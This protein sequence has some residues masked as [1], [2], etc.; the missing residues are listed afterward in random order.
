M[1]NSLYIWKPEIVIHWAE[2]GV[3]FY[4]LI[5]QNNLIRYFMF[6]F[7]IIVLQFVGHLL[8]GCTMG[9]MVT[10]SKRAFTTCCA[11]QVCCSQS[12]Y[13]PVR[14]LLIRG[15]AGGTQ[16]H[17]SRSSSVSCE[18]WC[19]QSFFW[20]LQVSLAFMGFDSKHEFIPPIILLGLLLCSWMCF[21]FVCLFVCL[22]LVGANILL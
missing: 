14:P 1:G 9:L 16:T 22:F 18:S 6:Y 10:F 21:L 20:A 7:G 11:S 2:I 8:S 15:S 12:P 3:Y 13:S 19:E 5:Q 17:K 4:P